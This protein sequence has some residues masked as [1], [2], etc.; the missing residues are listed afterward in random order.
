MYII[1][2]RFK[3]SENFVGYGYSEAQDFPNMK[4]VDREI[5]KIKTGGTYL[6]GEIEE[7]RPC[8][9]QWANV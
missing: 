6:R 2:I 3:G 8:L 1:C 4:A 9:V 7:I 5:A